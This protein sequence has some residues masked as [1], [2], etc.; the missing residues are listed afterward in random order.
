MAYRLAENVRV[1][2]ERWGLLF[3]SPPNHK[4]C[5]VKSGDW[6]SP[7][8]LAGEWTVTGLAARIAERTGTP[9]EVIERPLQKMTGQLTNSRM[10]VDELR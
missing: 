3:Y 6:L 1:R 5:F 2:K 9:A 4:V 7:D 8:N 10:V